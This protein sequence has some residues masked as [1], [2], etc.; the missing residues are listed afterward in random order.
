MTAREERR[1][2]GRV[3]VELAGVTKRFGPATAAQDVSFRVHRGQI[4]ALLGPSGSGKTT[5][6]RLI[7]GLERPEA[8]RIAVDGRTVTGPRTFVPPEERRVGLVFQDYALF[9]HLTIRQNVRFGL[10]G[11]TAD[12]DDQ[13]TAALRLVGLEELAD[14]HP[15]Q[16]SGGE[17]QRVALAR[18]LAPN[19]VVLLLDEPF[20]NLD[21][22]L[23]AQVRREVV[24]ILRRAG[25]TTI[26][27]THD[28]EEAFSIADRVGVL[29]RGVLRQVDT[30][31]DVYHRPVD[32]YVAQ[33]VGLADFLPGRVEDGEVSTEI[34]AF[35][36]A[37][38][39]P[40]GSEVEVM[41]RPD[42]IDLVPAAFAESVVVDREFRG[43]ESVY[44]VRLPSG[45][46]VHSSQPGGRVYR[47]G[48]RV[49]VIANPQHLV[50]F[51]GERR[52]DGTSA[53]EAR[54]R[55][56]RDVG[57]LMAKLED[58][59][60]LEEE[61]VAFYADGLNRSDN[62]VLNLLYETFVQDSRRHMNVVKTIMTYL[63]SERPSQRLLVSRAE[64]IRQ[65][66]AQ[67]EAEDLVEEE[68]ALTD[69][70]FVKLLL[71]SVSYDEQ[72]HAR[73]MEEL[74]RL[75]EKGPGAVSKLT[76][77]E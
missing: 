52:V 38:G 51:A 1:E 27:V 41:I 30:P 70:P 65:Y 24:R 59:L 73:L 75:M 31:D 69:D 44:T 63:Q 29:H 50:F 68:M 40:D 77:G 64:Q 58:H 54:P 15:H 49:L 37:P 12:G 72:K 2:N 42:D 5:I 28:Q 33:F 20:S 60:H 10:R 43:S 46:L 34:A 4:F 66:M 21:A 71:L 45:R 74:I 17:Q 11:P 16:L 32:R 18:A 39:L 6:L 7:A 25:T 14:R 56:S 47:P 3:L 76:K 36:N 53:T 19:P 67:E 61:E 35:Q 55:P 8:G 23:R 26:F 57:T 13:T 22:D 62:V 9:P 48:T